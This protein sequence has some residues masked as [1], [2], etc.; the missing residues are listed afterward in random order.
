MNPIAL[1]PSLYRRQ[2]LELERQIYNL[3]VPY[4]YSWSGFLFEPLLSV[5]FG[6]KIIIY[7]IQGCLED[8][9][10]CNVPC[11]MPGVINNQLTAVIIVTVV[12]L[13]LLLWLLLSDYESQ[14]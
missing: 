7:P 10:R 6:L 9:I 3:A 8:Q 4:F 12:S 2:I 13:L 14:C 11:T 1:V 5:K